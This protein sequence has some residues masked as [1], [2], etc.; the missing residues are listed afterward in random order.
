MCLGPHEPVLSVPKLA[1]GLVAWEWD[2]G[3]LG[4]AGVWGWAGVPWSSRASALC[5]KLAL[6]DH[7]QDCEAWCPG[8]GVVVVVVVVEEGRA[9]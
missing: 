1:H 4:S 6:L 9:G 8:S 2:G 3:H 5:Q 7:G